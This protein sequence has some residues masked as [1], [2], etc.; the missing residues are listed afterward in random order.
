MLKRKRHGRYIYT[1]YIVYTYCSVYTYSYI[2][3][4]VYKEKVVH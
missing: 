4:K 2:H 1:I 3:Y